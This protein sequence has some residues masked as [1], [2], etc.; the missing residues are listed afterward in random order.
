MLFCLSYSMPM[1]IQGRE[2]CR[3]HYKHGHLMF[4]SGFRGELGYSEAP[5]HC[6]PRL[7]HS[8]LKFSAEQ[9]Y[10]VIDSFMVNKH[11]SFHS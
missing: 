6:I 8:H 3:K 9:N 7:Q 1:S 11:S 2:S 4:Y 10:L 5:K